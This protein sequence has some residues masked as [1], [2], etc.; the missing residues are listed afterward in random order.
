M[1]RLATLLVAALFATGFTAPTAWAADCTWNGS[2]GNNWNNAANWTPSQ[3][4]GTGDTASIPAGNNAVVIDTVVSISGLNIG[5]YEHATGDASLTIAAGGTLNSN[6]AMCLYGPLINAGTLNWQD[7]GI[8]MFNHVGNGWASSI[9]NAVGGVCNISCDDQMLVNSEGSAQFHNLGTLRKSGGT[10]TIYFNIFL[11]NTGAVAVDSGSIQLSEGGGKLGGT[12][13]AASGAAF[14]L[15]SGTFELSNTPH[16]QGLGQLGVNG[17]LVLSGAFGGTFGIVSGSLLTGSSLTVASGGVLNISSTMTLYGDLAVASGGMLNIAATVHLRGPL[18]NTGTLIWQDGDL[19]VDHDAINEFTGEITNATG[20][21][22]NI[23][24]DKFMRY[25]YDPPQFHNAGILRKTAG[26]G[27]TEIAVMFDNTGT[28]DVQ[29]GTLRLS[30]GV[31]QHS[32]TYLTG[33][34]WLLSNGSTLDFTQGTNITTNQAM[35]TLDGGSCSFARFTSA[36]ADNQGGLTLR[37]GRTFT[38]S[39]NFTTSG[40]L[41]IEGDSTSLSV[42]GTFAQTAGNTTLLDGATITATAATQSGGTLGGVG[43]IHVTGT[44]PPVLTPPPNIVVAASAAVGARVTFTPSASGSGVSVTSTPPSGSFFPSGV[45]TVNVAATNN[46]GNA[47]LGTFTVTVVG[48]NSCTIVTAGP[49]RTA[50]VSGTLRGGPNGSVKLQASSDLGL[51]DPWEDIGT[52]VLDASGN[53]TFGPIQDP[54]SIG[55][56]KDFFRVRLP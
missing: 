10:G 15:V 20:G 31:T 40:T 35:V 38:T 21:I 50:S 41:R 27:S 17:D 51:T 24:C 54:H 3:V 26:S 55:L 37:N 46:S 8:T 2:A 49:S 14:Y 19:I 53:A 22:F 48:V 36:L 56:S 13:T 28:T 34:T 6:G 25:D 1:K 12:F 52:V 18:I 29:S 30:G 32:G 33:G 39:G 45:T 47:V 9:T 11:D 44:T 7:G 23:Q 5:D 43:T 4:P 16:F 42:T